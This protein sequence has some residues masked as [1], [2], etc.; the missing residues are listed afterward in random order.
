MIIGDSCFGYGI[1]YIK[2]LLKKSIPEVYIKCVHKGYNELQV[3]LIT[4]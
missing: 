3:I 4:N 2:Q 1:D